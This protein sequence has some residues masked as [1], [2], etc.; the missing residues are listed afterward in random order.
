MNDDHRLGFG[1]EQ[2]NGRIST[3]H[4]A[5]RI[6]SRCSRSAALSKANLFENGF[7]TLLVS[8]RDFFFTMEHDEVSLLV[9]TAR[10]A[11]DCHNE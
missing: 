2:L 9:S 11:F 4:F 1:S 3:F 7:F 6:E 5:K 8:G 10:Q